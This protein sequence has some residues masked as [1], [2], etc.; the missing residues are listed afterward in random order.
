MIIDRLS[1]APDFDVEYDEI[2]FVVKKK[3][4]SL[5]RAYAEFAI[6]RIDDSPFDLQYLLSPSLM[7]QH[8]EYLRGDAFQA[9]AGVLMHDNPYPAWQYR[10]YPVVVWRTIQL[11]NRDFYRAVRG[12][13]PFLTTEEVTKT[14]YHM[15]HEI[16]EGNR[17]P[18]G[19]GY[20]SIIRLAMAE[21]EEDPPWQTMH[22][23]RVVLRTMWLFPDV[24]EEV[25]QKCR[26]WSRVSQR[27]MDQ[28]L[29]YS[30]MA[31]DTTIGENEYNQVPF[32]GGV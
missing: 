4:E 24:R 10:G 21:E 31:D 3:T 7:R 22:E 12:L 15:C 11:V 25:S 6:H 23:R 5:F 29:L 26:M 28:W 9:Y 19:L 27:V 20:D 17:I 1:H 32:C 18:R 8:W 13:N 2:V 14:I 30:L 16:A